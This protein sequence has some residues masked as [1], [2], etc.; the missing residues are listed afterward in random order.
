[1]KKVLFTLLI[2][3]LAV[4]VKAQVAFSYHHST[5]NSSFGISSN[6]DKS[7]WAEARINTVSSEFDLTGMLLVNAVK[8]DD[9]K[10]YTGA[11]F[12]S[13]LFEGGF[14]LALGFTVKPIEA[15]PN[16]SLFGEWNPLIPTEFD[17]YI[18]TGS[19]GIR[20][21]LRKKPK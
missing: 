6:P 7:I 3:C 14:S 4:T 21:F 20:Y 8:R 11:G 16:F 15:K 9:F 13:L 18:S 17:D 2:L 19:I 5:L 12:T 10:L 1:M